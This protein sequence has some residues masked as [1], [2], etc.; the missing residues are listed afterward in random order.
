MEGAKH[1]NGGKGDNESFLESGNGALGGI[2]LMVV[3]GGQLDVDQF[4]PDVFLN[5]GGT[6]VVHYI[7]CRMVASCIQYGDDFGECLFHGSIGGRRHGL[8]CIKIVD[9]C[10]KHV[11]H[12]FEGADREGTGDVGIHG[13]S[14]GISKCGKTEHILHGTDFLRGEHA[15]N[16]GTCRDNVGLHIA[17]GGCIGSVLVHVALVGSNGA[18]QIFFD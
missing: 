17:R 11:L 4:G 16:L 18:R 12:T 10:N 8:D 7:Q 9:V 5:C 1:I 13:A 3:G 6:L 2:D 14:Y 15:V